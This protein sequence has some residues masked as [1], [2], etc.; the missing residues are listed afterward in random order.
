MTYVPCLIWLRYIEPWLWCVQ[1]LSSFLSSSFC[2]FFN[3]RTLYIPAPYHLT[4]LYGGFWTPLG[5]L[6]VSIIGSHWSVCSL[7]V[8]AC[9]QCGFES[10][11]LDGANLGSCWWCQRTRR[12][13]QR[14]L[15]S[16]CVEVT[17]KCH[18]LGLSLSSCFGRSCLHVAV[19]LAW[20]LHTPS[21]QYLHLWPG[22]TVSRKYACAD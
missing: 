19:A 13:G 14:E 11:N 3:R 4:H 21:L 9:L 5:L 15:S 1:P 10:R 20:L 6:E 7:V 2:C 16:I 12:F 8:F 17:L 22:N 18:F